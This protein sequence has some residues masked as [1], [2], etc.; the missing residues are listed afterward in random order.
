MAELYPCDT[1]KVTFHSLLPDVS[2]ALFNSLIRCGTRVQQVDVR[3]A[4]TKLPKEQDKLL[5]MFIEGYLARGRKQLDWN[6]LCEQALSLRKATFVMLLISCGA[7]PS[8]LAVLKVVDSKKMDPKLASY[9]AQGSSV[10]ARTQLLM[11]ALSSTNIEMAEVALD[12]GEI[13][14]NCINLSDCITAPDIVRNQQLLRKLLKAGVS[15][16]GSGRQNT[17]ALVLQNKALLRDQQVHLVC[18]LLEWGADVSQICTAY[19]EQMSPIHAATKLALESG[20]H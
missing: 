9:I 11:E 3:T 6:A 13:D 20:G 10:K 12:S 16:N 2:V 4:V 1:S 14:P 5:K 15:P 8:P 7:K 19:E 17:V 18:A